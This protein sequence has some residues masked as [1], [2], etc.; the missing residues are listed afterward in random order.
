MVRPGAELRLMTNVARHRVGLAGGQRGACVSL[1]GILGLLVALKRDVGSATLDG[2]YADCVAVFRWLSELDATSFGS[3]EA[4]S[5]RERLM[6][7]CE[8]LDDL[9]ATALPTVDDQ[10]IRSAIEQLAQ[11]TEFLSA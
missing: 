4:Q 5:M 7:I 1:A 6:A 8:G 11:I 2:L 9:T 10:Q 3:S